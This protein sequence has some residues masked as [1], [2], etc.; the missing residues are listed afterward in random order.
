MARTVTA[1]ALIVA[2][3]ALLLSLAAPTA[4]AKGATPSG[5]GF[6]SRLTLFYGWTNYKSQSALTN[7][8]TDISGNEIG[9]RGELEYWLGNRIGLA[10]DG[11]HISGDMSPATAES[12]RGKP[13][14]QDSV[15][16]ELAL[17][18]IGHGNGEN[19]EV[20][21][22]AGPGMSFYSDVRSYSNQGFYD[23]VRVNV[24]GA[25]VGAR[26]R[27]A[28]EEH[29]TLQLEGHW[30]APLQLLGQTHTELDRKHS[31]N[32]LGTVSLEYRYQ[33]GVGIG[34]GGYYSL[35]RVTY[36]PNPAVPPQEVDFDIAAPFVYLRFGL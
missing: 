17:K 19:T 30:F 35:N 23:L 25:R 14:T 31:R 13:I 29:F 21:A 26:A 7:S 24:F 12:F 28:F 9:G 10:L 11:D 36:Q 20:V 27:L 22:L 34:L 32:A 3:F 6:R 18:L 8:V 4:Q 15:A 5:D 16:A 33:S 1:L 2:L